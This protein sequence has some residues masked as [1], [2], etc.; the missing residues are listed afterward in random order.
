MSDNVC[1]RPDDPVMLESCDDMEQGEVVFGSAC[2]ESLEVILEALGIAQEVIF[3]GDQQ[4]VR[5]IA[6][7]LRPYAWEAL[8]SRGIIDPD[9]LPTTPAPPDLC[10]QDYQCFREL[11]IAC[12][13]AGLGWQADVT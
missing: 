5:R 13:D 8:F 4:D 9:D 12:A 7:A 1:I 6:E 3:S 10:A 11:A 2:W